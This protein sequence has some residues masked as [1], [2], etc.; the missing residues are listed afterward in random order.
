MGQGH[1]LAEPLLDVL[2]GQC[3]LP[4]IRNELPENVELAYQYSMVPELGT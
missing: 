1:V 3:T 4:A 2:K